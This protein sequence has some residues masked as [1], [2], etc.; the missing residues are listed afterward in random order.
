M[1]DSNTSRMLSTSC[2]RL[3]IVAYRNMLPLT[4]GLE[5]VLG[6]RVHLVQAP[7]S[8]LAGQLER[9][10]ID[11]GMVPVASLFDNPHWRILG[12]SMIGARGPVASVLA[13]GRPPYQDWQSLRPDTHSMTSNA[14]GWIVLQ[15][16]LGLQLN[17]GEPIPMHDWSP[18]T[19]L[20]EATGHILIGSRALRLGWRQQSS[21]Q[22]AI[23][24]LGQLW[25]EWTGLPMVFAV[26]AARPGVN[27]AELADTLESLKKNN[28]DRIETLSHEPFDP[29]K[30]GLDPAGCRAYLTQNVNYEL[31]ERALQG[32]NRFYSE[33]RQAGLFPEGWALNEF[34]S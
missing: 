2:L 26:W 34:V 5:S 15:R 16:Y 24:D 7:P 30:D 20:T 13:V 3:G 4:A 12:R 8:V 6:H 27:A 9:G 11:V 33:G 22:L 1:G 29:Y 10:E 31:D 25:V 17:W 28:L 14:L 23:L 19:D 32:L 21:H 18:Q